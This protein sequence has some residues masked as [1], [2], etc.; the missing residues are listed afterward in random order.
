[1]FFPV[2]PLYQNALLSSVS[3]TS[4]TLFSNV[5]NRSMGIMPLIN[6]KFEPF[7]IGPQQKVKAWNSY[8]SRAIVRFPSTTPT[9][10][11]Y[12]S[13]VFPT[14]PIITSA[15]ICFLVWQF[16]SPPSR[17]PTITDNEIL[18]I[19]VS[20]ASAGTSFLTAYMHPDPQ[21]RTLSLLSGISSLL[22]GPITLV[23]GLP[24]INTE[25]LA[26]GKQNLSED[27]WNK[28]APRVNELVQGWEKRHNIRFIG[29]AGGWVFST[30]ALLTA[31][32]QSGV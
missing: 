26:L 4:F 21:V 32:A 31:L 8:F 3:M 24:A 15:L 13:P 5:A 27:E 2:L 17:C 20:L 28:R 9:P 22:I 6:Q 23:S 12:R 16:S 10:F 18:A 1:M 19:G 29:F 14:L 30:A 11:R 7:P 25:L